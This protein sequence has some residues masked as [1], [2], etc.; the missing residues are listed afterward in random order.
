MICAVYWDYI[1]DSLLRPD[2][3]QLL[4]WGRHLVDVELRQISLDVPVRTAVVSGHPAEVL[5]NRSKTAALL[6]VGSRGHSRLDPL[7]LGSVS[8][9]CAGAARCPTLVTRL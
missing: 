2:D 5:V 1:G 8:A 3:A 7:M 9:H 6:V 4:G